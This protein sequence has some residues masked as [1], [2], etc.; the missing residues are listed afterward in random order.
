M[1]LE[2]KR[3]SPGGS[4][5]RE[6][7]CNK[8][9]L[10]LIPGWGRSPGGGNGYPLR[11]SCLENPMDR[12][13]W[14]AAVRVCVCVCVCVCVFGAIQIQGNTAQTVNWM[15]RRI[16]RCHVVGIFVRLN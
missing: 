11:Y 5:S 2:R 16:W 12:G 14:Q 13:A 10:G 9:D 6:S 3:G 4:D 15:A 1:N 7:T 8:G